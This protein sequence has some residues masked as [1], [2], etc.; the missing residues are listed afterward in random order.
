MNEHHHHHQHGE[1][2]HGATDASGHDKHA[3]HSV[4]MFRDKFWLS[5]ALTIPTVIWEPM[6]QEW[7]GYTAPQF[8]GSALIPALFGTIVFIYGGWVFLR[9]AIGELKT[10]LPGM[11]TLISLAISVAFIYSVAVLFGF[12]GHPLWWE[13]ATLVTIMLLGHW[14]EMRSISQAQG[15][16]NEL[17]KLLPDMAVRVIEG[18]RTEEVAVSELKADDIVLVRPGA[19]I[20]ADGIV[21]SGKSSV[22][23]SMI[24]GES[25]LVDKTDAS[26]VLGGT[27]NGQGSL[28]VRVLQTGQDTALAGIMRLVSQAQSSRSRAQ[29]LADRAAFLL[30]IVAILAGAATFVAWSLLG[31]EIDFTVTRMVTVLVIACPHALGLAV[32]L[33][34]AIST[35]LGARNGLLIRDRRGL[36]EARNLD[37]VVFDKTGTLTLGAHRVVEIVAAQGKDP[38]VA[39]SLAAAVERDSEHPIAQALLKSAEDKGIGLPP[40]S[41]FQAAAGRGVEALV[42]GRRF[43]VGG[44]ALLDERNV[45]LDQNMENASRRIGE[46]G[47]AAIYLLEGDLIVAVFAIADQVRPES[48]EAVAK[49]QSMGIEVVILTGDSE[50]VARSVGRDLGIDTVFSG[51]LPDQKSDKIKELQAQGKRVAMVGDGVND[52]PALV[53][54]DV[55]IA[56]GAGTDVAV[57]AGDVV[58]VRSDPRDIAR[59]V[60]LSRATY[61]KMI[62]NLWWAAGYNIVAIPL[63]AG[64]LYWAGIVLAPAVGAVLMSASTVIVAINAQLLRRLD[65]V[66]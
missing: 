29:A 22:N 5:L 58:L 46:N 2:S 8:A 50:A 15:A 6:I 13:L 35:T 59:I 37:T 12:D 11:M 34:T 42:E 31:A 52:A 44:P 36:E 47:Q 63:A 26:E 3:G 27:V 65:M 45:T 32:P 17:A 23:E 41:E 1:A 56:I 24:T 61:R 39:L 30:T 7:F 38:D 62:Q 10:R 66:R 53:T 43:A 4:S 21:I 64:V 40:S 51:V 18:D 33:V 16:L 9:S 20:P 57:E 28:R 48:R 14:I 60:T 19:S 25:A 49:L 55:G 54:A